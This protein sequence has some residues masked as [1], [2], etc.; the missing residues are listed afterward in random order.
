MAPTED[1]KLK[2]RIEHWIEHNAEHAEE[3]KVL[4][5]AIKSGKNS[6]VSADLMKAAEEIE[7]A[8]KW[9]REALEKIGEK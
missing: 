3:F 9:L 1:E 2:I 6:D 8:N 7:R 5:A 4:S